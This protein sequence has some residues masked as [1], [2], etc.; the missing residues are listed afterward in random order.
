[1]QLTFRSAQERPEDFFNILQE[2]WR[3]LIAPYWEVYKPTSTIY[4]L[5]VD[6]EVVAGGIVFGTASPDMTD[7]E[8]ENGKIYFALGYLY[9][10]FLW[11][12]PEYRGAK[13]G[14]QWLSLLKKQ[15]KNQSFWLTIEEEHLKAFYKKNDFMCVA[16]NTQEGHEEWLMVYVPK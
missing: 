1:M 7:F 13:L 2:D 12:I 11:V 4:V 10:G 14:S 3:V 5:E 16:E 15:K 8:K 9:I 6:Q